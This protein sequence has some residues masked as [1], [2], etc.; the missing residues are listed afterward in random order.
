[1][2]PNKSKIKIDSLR[3]K[4]RYTFLDFQIPMIMNIRTIIV[5]DTP[6]VTNIL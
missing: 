4:L 3:D 2:S 1:M 5:I 6:I